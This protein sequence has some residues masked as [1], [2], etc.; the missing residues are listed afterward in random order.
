MEVRGTVKVGERGVG[1]GVGR[2]AAAL[3]AAL[4]ALGAFD[5]VGVIL[6]LLLCVLKSNKF[7]SLPQLQRAVGETGECYDISCRA[8]HLVTSALPLG[9]NPLRCVAEYE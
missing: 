6:A 7:R 2:G 8:S 3:G 4:A 1:V 5:M 9:R